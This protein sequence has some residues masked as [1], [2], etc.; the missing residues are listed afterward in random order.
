MSLTSWP[1]VNICMI[2]DP[3]PWSGCQIATAAFCYEMWSFLKS[4]CLHVL[5][6]V[7][8]FEGFIEWPVVQTPV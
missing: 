3:K 8:S 6:L 5:L 4:E 1:C 2:K 7:H